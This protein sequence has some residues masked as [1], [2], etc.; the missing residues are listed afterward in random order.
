[1]KKELS[2][3]ELAALSLKHKIVD[4]NLDEWLEFRPEIQDDVIY[5]GHDNM[6]DGYEITKGNLLSATIEESAAKGDSVIHVNLGWQKVTLFIA[7]WTH[8][9]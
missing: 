8:P 4:T 3:E 7:D 6:K 9:S 2:F 5:V 1:M